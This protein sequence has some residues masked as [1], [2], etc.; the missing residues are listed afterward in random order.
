MKVAAAEN[1]LYKQTI[2]RRTINEQQ[3]NLNAIPQCI[4]RDCANNHK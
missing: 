2:D 1:L 4:N 3:E